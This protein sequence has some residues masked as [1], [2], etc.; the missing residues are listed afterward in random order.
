MLNVQVLGSGCNNC[1]T[2]QTR[3]EQAVR[4][5]GVEANVRLVTDMAVMM[6]YGILNTPALVINEKVV[7]AGRVPATS[8]I[9]TLLLA[10]L[11]KSES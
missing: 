2:V 8:Q 11:E 10:A 3:A 6:R 9:K 7:L 5:L 4:E 1:H